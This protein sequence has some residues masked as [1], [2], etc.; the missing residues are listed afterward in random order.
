MRDVGGKIAVFASEKSSHAASIVTAS[1]IRSFSHAQICQLTSLENLSSQ[2]KAIVIINPG[3]A[4]F[5]QVQ[6]RLDSGLKLILLGALED[7]WAALLGVQIVDFPL[8]DAAG[9]TVVE[10]VT[11]HYSH[12]LWG[13]RYCQ[14]ELTNQVPYQIRY[15][16][17]YDFTDEWNNHG[18]GR[19]LLHEDD[20]Y[21]IS[22]CVQCAADGQEL[23]WIENETGDRISA[24]CVQRDEEA[25]SLL[26]CNRAVG[27]VDSLEWTILENYLGNYRSG[28][29]FCFPYLM[30]VPAGFTGVCTMRLDCDQA[31]A[32]ARR[33]SICIARPRFLFHWQS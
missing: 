25:L 20:E 17:R 23:S 21:A 11:G 8:A 1:L 22:Q 3:E 19:V 9:D 33:Y 12:S 4:E 18:Y 15:L 2:I 5:K 32:S 26:W 31:V 6:D 30:E 13:I 29:L 10:D 27:L 24:Y 16:S 14:H 28:E 7:C